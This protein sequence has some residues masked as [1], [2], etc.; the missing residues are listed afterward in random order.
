MHQR[1]STVCSD[2]GGHP[3]SGGL[4]M[5]TGLLYRISGALVDL[6]GVDTI[7]SFGLRTIIDMRAAEEDR[8]V[9]VRCAADAGIRYQ[10]I[11]IDLAR[12][13]ALLAE[14]SWESVTEAR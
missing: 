7:T 12:P 9:L 6:A 2:V 14:L 4:T 13:H 8:H 1:G 5:R 3:A 11:P 10:H